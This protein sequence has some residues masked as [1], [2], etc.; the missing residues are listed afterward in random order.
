[1]VVWIETGISEMIYV[2]LSESFSIASKTLITMDKY[3][4]Y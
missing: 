4:I 2:S 1:M 3:D